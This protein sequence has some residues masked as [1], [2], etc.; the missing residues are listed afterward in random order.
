MKM[1]VH[2]YNFQ[3]STPTSN[4]TFNYTRLLRGGDCN[5]YSFPIHC[6]LT[7]VK[8]EG[9]IELILKTLSN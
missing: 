3:H 5:L 4:Q 1:K 7:L 9:N 8:A 2:G 6:L